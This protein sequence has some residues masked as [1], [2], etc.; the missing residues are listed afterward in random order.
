MLFGLS[1]PGASGKEIFTFCVVMDVTIS[2][3]VITIS[4]VYMYTIIMLYP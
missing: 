1:Q 4:K 2:L 3:T